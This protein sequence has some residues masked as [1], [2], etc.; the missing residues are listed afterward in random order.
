MDLDKNFLTIMG[1][2]FRLHLFEGVVSTRLRSFLL[3]K[4]AK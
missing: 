3:W 2:V 4:E 1:V